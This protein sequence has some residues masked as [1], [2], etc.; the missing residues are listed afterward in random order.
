[1]NRLHI[2]LLVVILVLALVVRFVNLD[3]IPAGFHSD[4][5]SVGYNAYSLSLTG[6]DDNGKWFPVY[7]DIFGDNRLAAIHYLAILPVK[8]FGLNEFATRFFAA[9]FGALTVFPVYFLAL[10]IFQNR[11]IAVISS[12]ILAFAPWSIVF[13]RAT[14]ESLIAV[15]FVISG[16]SFIAYA[17]RTNR[18]LFYSLGTIAFTVSFF[19]YHTPRIFIPLLFFSTI[20]YFFIRKKQKEQ[21]FFKLGC[22]FLLLSCL[23]FSLIFLV[24]GGTGRF[25]QVNIFSSFETGFQ[26]RKELQEDTIAGSPWFL[27]RFMHNKI[28][29]DAYMFVSNYLDYFSGNFLF[30]KGGLPLWYLVSRAGVLLAIELPFVLYGVYVLLQSKKEIHKALLIWILVA[31]VVAAITIDDI[32][33]T[34]RSMVLFPFLDMVAAAGL[35][36]FLDKFTKKKQRVI[37]TVVGIF[38]LANVAYFLHQYFYNTKVEKPWYRN[39]GFGKM[40]SVV[41]KSYAT[42]D[43]VVMTKYQGETYPLVL[44]YMQYDPREYQREGSPKAKDY[45]GF[46]KFFFAPQD[47]PSTQTNEKTPK[48]EHILFIDKGDCPPDKSLEQKHYE[49]IYRED[50]TKAFRIVY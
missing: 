41:K 13:S 29:N 37:L 14:N 40:M 5:A 25:N 45:A 6:R 3:Q 1:M 30:I 27:S 15:F 4:E 21:Y 34:Q 42:Y 36:F 35:V 10:G 33:N 31:P 12:L 32:P 24:S 48:V 38:F 11:K 50:G 26:L 9:V 18:I 16:L 22:V 7:I 23:S 39:N 8:I 46:G 2:F 20:V 43:K 28:T 17:I 19:L 49:Y 44:F 47:C